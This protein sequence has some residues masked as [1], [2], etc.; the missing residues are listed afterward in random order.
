[1]DVSL[2]QGLDVLQNVGVQRLAGT[3]RIV[4]AQ[5]KRSKFMASGNAVEGKAAVI[6]GVKNLH[7][8]EVRACD[9]RAGAALMLAGL[10]AEGD[11][12]VKG[13]SY[14]YRGYENICKDFRELGARVI[15]V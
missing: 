3:G 4:K 6:D 7:G 14:I 10:M 13:Y 1:M 8:C 2:A 11:T 9:L 5:H 15:S 12:Y